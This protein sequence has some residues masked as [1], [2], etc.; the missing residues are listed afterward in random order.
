VTAAATAVDRRLRLQA[1]VLT[2]QIARRVG[3]RPE[4]AVGRGTSAVAKEENGLSA[5]TVGRHIPAEEAAE[6]ETGDETS[7][8]RTTSP[9]RRKTW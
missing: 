7:D 5:R 3:G 8:Q 4:V 1:A 6:T 9:T 2:P